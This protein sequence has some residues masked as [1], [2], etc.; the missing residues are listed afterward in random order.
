[1]RPTPPRTRGRSIVAG[2]TTAV[3]GFGLLA[4]PAAAAETYPELT[5]ETLVASDFTLYFANVGAQVVDSVADGDHLGLYQTLTDQP[6]STD[7][8]TG[9]S[10]GYVVDATSNPVANTSTGNDRLVS[11]RYDDEPAG[12]DLRTR[13]VA[14][15]FDLPSGTYDLTVGFS[16]PSGWGGRQVVTRAEGQDLETFDTGTGPLEKSYAD[17]QVSDGTLDVAVASPVDRTSADADPMV[18]YVIVRADQQWTVPVLE[19]Q[20]A[21]FALS[22][23]EAAGY[24]PESVA[25]LRAA[26]D[27]AR[28][29][30]DA[31]STD[32][33]AIEAAY[34]AVAVA[35]AA[36]R[37]IV[38]YDSFR[39]GEPWLDTDGRVIQAHGGQVVP[40]TDEAGERI[41]YWYGEDR[42]N[43]YYD[44][45]GVH[46]YSSR[47]LYNWTDEGLALRAMSSPDQFTTDEYFAG[48]YA[49]YTTE[50][51]EVVWRDLSTNSVRTDGW[52][53]PSILERPKVI[54]NETT[55]QWVMW[56]HSD[57]PDSPTSTSTYARA[58]AGV[59]VADSPTG[60]FRWIDSYRLNNVP[61]DSVTWCGTGAA[62]DPAGGMARDMNLFVDD[63]GTAYIIYSSEEN[64]TMYISKLDADYTYLSAA[65][66]D[67]VQGRDFVRTLPC[68]QREAPAMFK[69]QGTYYL[70]TSG[71]TGWDPNPAQYATATEVLG[72]WTDRGNPITGEGAANTFR[73]Q[74][75]SVIPVDPATGRFIF[76][77]DRWTP[78][79]LAAAPY[80]W[81][82]IRF[83]EGGTV[84]LT[85]PQE[86]D[87]TDLE[88][89]QRWTVDTAMPDHV[90]LG[91]TRDLPAEVRVTTE[92][93]SVQLPVTWDE[94][95]VTQPGVSKVRGVLADGRTFT[96]DVLVVPHDLRYVVNAGGAETADWRRIV[97]VAEAEGALLNSLPEQ[98]LGADPVTGTSWG[99]TGASGTA[100]D[101]AGDIYSTL[102]YAMEKQP[103][104]Y[105]FGGLTPGTYTVRAGY[106]D[107]WPQANRAARVSVNGA[108]VD[109]ERLFA[110]AYTSG[111][112]DGIVVGEGGTI[113]VTI[114][115]T[116]SPD[117]QVSW[118]MVSAVPA[119]E[120]DP[121]PRP[122]PEFVDVRAGDAFYTD[123]RW[124]AERGLANGTRVG[125]QVY[126]YP[127]HPVSR[128]AMAAFLY[129]YSGEE[130]VPDGAPTFT[131]VGPDHQFYVAIEWMA[132]QGLA[133]GYDDGTFGATKPVSRQ[134]A[135]AF[136]HR[137][138]GEPAVG[139]TGGF[140]DV[141]VDDQFAE[142]IAWTARAGIA[143]GY[144]GEVFGKTRPVTRQAIAAFLHRYDTFVGVL[145]ID[146]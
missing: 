16:V 71:A 117:I 123:I 131:D 59:A 124:L 145:R 5:P 20:I 54:Y 23:E 30:A 43:G 35:H 9:H 110:S 103:L 39:P 121:K 31:G 134:A 41:W 17:V 32:V 87:L 56:V 53:A 96:R 55:D 139:G 113:T 108:M 48:L 72:Q 143:Q 141:P 49:D 109:E 115:P 67:A 65:P 133:Q 146:D 62:F 68:N 42:S 6:Y 77:G 22:D 100:G 101:A 95:T 28:A 45:P 106:H 58:E 18:S 36:L 74:S 25:D 4:S 144:D 116:R 33:V 29:L 21:R 125:D 119:P 84:S 127:A 138:A 3:L 91:D 63:D 12:A 76:M 122:V 128:Q 83:G 98:Q 85:A 114:E 79:D 15:A 38:T 61:S 27:E 132:A 52:A 80:V 137:L 34:R 135:A 93:T 81:L 94:T 66:Q 107:P 26:L 112:Y 75:T 97:D 92:G 130:F 64:R 10:W 118:L 142:A 7:A 105:T 11:L 70:I 19:A 126:F 57:G 13:Q 8:R 82:P 46:V 78:D 120:P 136:L 60:P 129:R 37:P 1:M 69:S 24:A 90:W 102:R 44:S 88:P 50:Q 73:S 2:A 40:A 104:V 86:W 89:Y 14:Y 51:R 99:F 47:D 111:T 140:V